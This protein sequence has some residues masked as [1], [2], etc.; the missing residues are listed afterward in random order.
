MKFRIK[1]LREN[2]N[3]SQEQLAENSGVSRTIISGLE[4]GR[5]EITTTETLR[6][7]AKAL[8]KSISDIFF[9]E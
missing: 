2:M 7:I 6:K 4:S 9:D 5:I 3:I 8:N 1:E